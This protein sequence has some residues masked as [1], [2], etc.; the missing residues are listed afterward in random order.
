MAN[1]ANVVDEIGGV[2]RDVRSLSPGTV[3]ITAGGRAA[4]DTMGSQ[5]IVANGVAFAPD[6]ALLVADTARGAIWRAQFD[7]S[8]N[9]LSRTG[10]DATFAPT[11]LCMENLLVA[12]PL[13]EGADGIAVDT[14][15]NVWVAA[16]ERNAL[17]V[18]TSDG[19]V[20]E[21]FRNP[22][23][24]GTNL[25]N[26]GPLEFPTSPFLLGNVVCMAQ[27]DTS[28]R[29]NGPS[30]L[31]ELNPDSGPRGKISCMDQSLGVPGLPLPVR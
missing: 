11:T 25:R 1:D 9:L 29:D 6:G 18:V 31:G 4:A 20:T 5:A 28:R 7:A 14:A 3:R 13:L 16:N 30:N 2:G 21:A 19:R 12:H 27:T 10:C 26:T 22:P 17:V 8:G 15:G 24:P 23:D